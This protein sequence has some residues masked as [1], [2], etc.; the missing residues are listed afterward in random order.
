MPIRKNKL[1]IAGSSLVL[2]SILNLL[3]FAMVT[4]AIGDAM[5]GEITNGHYFLDRRNQLT[6]VSPR[7]WRINRDYMIAV[8][9]TYPL[10]IAVGGILLWLDRRRMKHDR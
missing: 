1:A 6:E 3:V 5:K 2:I 8:Q 10:G 7:E 4:M 9:I